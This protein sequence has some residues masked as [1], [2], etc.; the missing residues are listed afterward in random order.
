MT[1]VVDF[2]VHGTSLSDTIKMSN[3][4][5]QAYASTLISRAYGYGG[6][7]TIIGYTGFESIYGGDGNDIL[8][9]ARFI[10]GG[11]G[12]DKIKG[13]NN[14]FINDLNGDGGNDTIIGSGGLDFIYGGTGDDTLD[15]GYGRDN[16]YGEG[17]NDN[18][19]GGY[20]TDFLYGGA[21]DDRFLL[22]G[23]GFIDYFFDQPG[24]ETSTFESGDGDFYAGGTGFDLLVADKHKHTLVLEN[25]SDLLDW[26]NS[27]EGIDGGNF[28]D[29]RVLVFGSG[30][31][32]FSS[33][34]LRNTTLVMYSGDDVVIGS[35]ANQLYDSD[36]NGI[37]DTLNSAT[38]NDKIDGGF[39]V[40]TVIFKGNRSD[41][42]IY[43]LG[44]GQFQ[45]WDQVGA[46]GNTGRDILVNFEKLQFLDQILDIGLYAQDD[47]AIG[48]TAV[49]GVAGTVSESASNGA[50][51]GIDL[52]ATPAA[53]LLS[54][55]PSAY[56]DSNIT[57]SLLDSAGGRFSIDS[58]TGIV[59]VADA[60]LLDYESAPFIGGSDVDRGFTIW[61][62]SS[63]SGIDVP[64]F[65]TILVTDTEENVAPNSPVDIDAASNAVNEGAANGTYTGVQAFASDPNTADI[66]TLSLAD[67]AGG[68][69]S[70][71]TNGKIYV[72]NGVALDFET[73]PSWDVTVRA[74]DAAGA[75]TDSVF[76][77]SLNNVAGDTPTDSDGAANSVIEGAANGTYTGLTGSLV[78]PTGSPVT[79]SLI[80]N[81]FG[82]F[83]INS[84]TGAVTVA[85]GALLDFETQSAWNI[86]VGATDGKITGSKVFTIN[87]VDVAGD[88]PT[89][90]DGAANSVIEGAANGTYTGL[91]G[92]LVSPTGSPVTYSL[93][94]SAFGRFQINS[95]TGAVTVANGALLDFE[96]QS[97]WN[98]TVGATDGKIT[99]SKVFTINLVNGNDAPG[100]VSDT[101]GADNIV[102]EGAAVGTVVGIAAQAIDPNGDLLTYSLVNNAGG[103]FAINASTGVIT[104]ANGA[105]LD[106]E[107]QSAWDVTVRATDG[108]GLYSEQL[109]TIDIADIVW[110]TLVDSDLA[111]NDI[112]DENAA[113]DTYTGVTAAAVSPS[114]EPV[115]YSLTDNAAGR[116]QIDASTGA[117]AVLDGNLLD[118][119]AQNA[120]N[121]TVSASDGST[122]HEQVFT[123]YLNDQASESW[124]GTSEDDIFTINR[125]GE[126]V[127]NGLGGNDVLTAT[128]GQH[129]TFI[130]G[131]G[132]DTLTGRNGND[133]FQYDGTANGLD[134]VVGG[135]GYDVIQ[136]IAGNTTIGLSAVSGI[137]EINGGGFAD[138]ILQLGAGNDVIDSN[139]TALTGIATIR[140]GAG[141]D[142]I[143]GTSADESIFGEDGNDLILGGGGG[144]ALNGGNGVDT[145]SY[146]GSW[147]ALTI[148]LA[149][150]AVSGGDATGDTITGFENVTGSDF[151]DSITG[152]TGANVISAGAGN[153]TLDGGAG[154]D[155][156][157][158]GLGND[159]YTVDNA[160]DVVTEN[161]SEG[162]DTV[163]TG[164]ASYTLGTN[165]ENLVYTG[166]TAFTGTGNTL[167]NALTG[168][169]GN[170]TLS[171]GDGNDTL[172]G[173]GGSDTLN[174]GAGNDTLNGG[175][176]TDTL[177][178]GLGDDIYVVDVA[179]DIV[180]EAANAGTDT[181]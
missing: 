23:S 140:A 18:I 71:G 114:G 28:F 170:D 121:V 178:G 131:D 150:N 8:E 109:F 122:A 17:G 48:G 100:T 145:V 142:S 158:G 148:N 174:G 20:L 176:G 37:D 96:T 110:D 83:Q 136:A 143:I 171:G 154:A 21:D 86:T 31:Q 57:F 166:T 169:A 68:R 95:T 49:N 69:F 74:T 164:L 111:T 5:P 33:V 39:G 134:A 54:F 112:V 82:R 58:S 175:A 87:L 15:G 2:T 67:D 118:F 50:G 167:N 151:N 94:S 66:V 85:N 161:A 29:F 129:I 46:N 56:F 53:G 181:V 173:L 9:S 26:D 104:V 133:V 35:S 65:F 52:S 43:Y 42:S 139:V 108:G 45:V 97:A 79:Y 47:S 3:F 92:S 137:E 62:N 19:R 155:T 81:A 128:D 157:V 34:F 22:T 99:G 78:S 152:S 27:I 41:Y 6:N 25:A 141:N 30:V 80:S 14:G 44:S 59:T 13:S 159:T 156:L 16:I 38:G 163:Q 177:V 98:I 51:V 130:G 103:R 7:D 24:G 93:I 32:D 84:T 138:V 76:A 172:T 180:T 147:D 106:F 160:G 107:S 55:V 124:F 113:T 70:I 115:T 63:V 90:S 127:L 1:T 153:D 126:W 36:D 125:L 91:T 135:D 101:D 61:V 105:L 77:I 60:S 116:F 89:D 102:N 40:D 12:D 75:F 162:T 4:F 179:T 149:T 144:D 165:V 117:I 10:Y 146:A 72:A 168:G 73:Q 120:W 88:T 11:E 119:E 64:N 132:N 123:I